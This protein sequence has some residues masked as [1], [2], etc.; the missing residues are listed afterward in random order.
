MPSDWPRRTARLPA[1]ALHAFTSRTSSSVLP[2]GTEPGFGHSST[3]LNPLCPANIVA[4]R[5]W[6]RF[7]T[8]EIR[9]PFRRTCELKP[10]M[11]LAWMPP[12]MT[13]RGMLAVTTNVIFHPL[14][15]AMRYA[16]ANRHTQHHREMT[17]ND[18]FDHLRKGCPS[19]APLVKLVPRALPRDSCSPRRVGR[20]PTKVI[21]FCTMRPIWSPSAP[22]MAAVSADSLEARAPLAFS[23]LSNQPTSCTMPKHQPAQGTEGWALPFMLQMPHTSLS[24]DTGKKRGQAAHAEANPHVRLI[25]RWPCALKPYHSSF[26]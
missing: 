9:A 8:F 19:S 25:R 17:W 3:I 16:T 2:D 23:S 1:H 20:S 5:S 4:D 15:K 18:V 21:R 7:L 26:R 22:R 10:V 14:L 11:T 24:T 12:A 13:M 6:R